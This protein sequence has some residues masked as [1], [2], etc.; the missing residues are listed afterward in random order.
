M[1]PL[2]IFSFPV[3]L[4]QDILAFCHPWDVAAFSKTCR[5]AYSLVYLPTDQ[6]LWRQLYINYF[7]PLK[8]FP[9]NHVASKVNWR[10]ELSDRMK[11]ELDL[12]RGPITAEETYKALEV[13]VKMV[14]ESSQAVL[15]TGSSRNLIWLRNIVRQTHLLS[16]I[17]TSPTDVPSERKQTYARLRTYLALTID[18]KK[19]KKT[20]NLLTGMRD[21]SRAF[22]YDLRN[23]TAD[24]KWGP[25]LPDGSVNWIH[26][27]HLINVVALNIRELPGSWALTRPP[28]CIDPPRVS[29]ANKTSLI[30]SPLGRVLPVDWAGVEGM[31]DLLITICFLLFTVIHRNLETICL[32]HGLSVCHYP[33]YLP[34]M[35][36]CLRSV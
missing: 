20:L 9:R 35:T 11:V 15:L 30:E 10:G 29:K 7:D 22:V 14:E 34:P 8:I 19:D 13:L 27:E 5:A 26:V 36:S 28:S 25:F 12:F 21:N 23:Y 18:P 4:A 33:R 24:T 16:N 1:T 6:Y 31:F 3:E 2:S 32:L 17:Y